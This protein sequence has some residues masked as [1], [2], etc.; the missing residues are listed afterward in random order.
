MRNYGPHGAELMDV[1]R[2]FNE[3]SAAD[4]PDDRR[5]EEVTVHWNPLTTDVQGAALDLKVG[6]EQEVVYGEGRRLFGIDWWAE[7]LVFDARVITASRDIETGD[8]DMSFEIVSPVRELRAAWWRRFG[9]AIVR[10]LP[11]GS[12]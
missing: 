11:G 10:Q 3:R 4:E 5:F 6:E 7:R 9:Y 8:C 12:S 2:Y 1:S